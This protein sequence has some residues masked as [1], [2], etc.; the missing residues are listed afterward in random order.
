MISISRHGLLY[1]YIVIQQSVF[2]GQEN[3][4]NSVRNLN[5]Q[6]FLV[7]NISF[8][9]V[10]IACSSA[11]NHNERNK[12]LI[13][14]CMGLYGAFS[15]ADT[16]FLNFVKL[17]RIQKEMYLIFDAFR[18]IRILI[19]IIVQPPKREKEKKAK[20][21]NFRYQIIQDILII[22]DKSPRNQISSLGILFLYLSLPKNIKKNFSIQTLIT[23]FFSIEM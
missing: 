23:R 14:C 19:I 1:Q 3:S 22:K 15:F 8:I 12:S 16:C 13:T 17:I 21:I 10:N 5:R 9:P 20:I 11:T 2:Q 7:I 4:Y 18:C 6:K